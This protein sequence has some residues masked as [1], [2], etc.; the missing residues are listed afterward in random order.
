MC[1]GKGNANLTFLRD[2][3]G[4]CNPV[5]THPALAVPTFSS[6]PTFD[7]GCAVETSHLAIR[8]QS[9]SRD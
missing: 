3:G 6:I 7:S 4:G 9:S 2:F 5:F 8:Y 1:G